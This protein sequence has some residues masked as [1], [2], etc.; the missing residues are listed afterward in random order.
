MNDKCKKA[1][2]II[3]LY[4]LWTILLKTLIF[5]ITNILR[6]RNNHFYIYIYI[7]EISIGEI[8][9]FINH[10][11]WRVVIILTFALSGAINGSGDVFFN[12]LVLITRSRGERDRRY[13]ARSIGS[14]DCWTFRGAISS[15]HHAL[16]HVPFWP[17]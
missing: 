10:D 4:I 2:V 6:S 16:T 1:P 7:F 5:W 12:S 13:H 17:Y 15:W 8:F 9:S 3:P 14:R 11:I